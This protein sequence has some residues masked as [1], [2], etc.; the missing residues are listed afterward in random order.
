MIEA[1]ANRQDTKAA[2]DHAILRL[3][4]DLALRRGEVV[5]LDLCDLDLASG[6]LAI[7][8]K[9]R[10]QKTTLRLPKPTKAALSTWA[11]VRGKK[12]GAL[13]LNFDRAKKGEGR[14]SGTSLY[15]IVQKLG[16]A[17]GVKVTPHGLRHTAITEA[18]KMAALKGIDLEEVL[19]FSRH[20][21]IKVLMV[22]RDRERD[23][24]GTLAN[25]VAKEV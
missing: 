15:R 12:P 9:G 20:T 24:A 17:V 1:V 2:R 14:L 21:D 5:S 10:T 19:D 13:F 16:K 18:C 11:S 23:V 6:T 8:G 4:Y 7:Q 25:L 3:L 22:Y